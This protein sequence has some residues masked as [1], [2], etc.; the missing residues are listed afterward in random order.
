MKYLVLSL[1]LLTTVCIHAQDRIKTITG[2][3]IHAE[4]LDVDSYFLYYKTEAEAS[5]RT[6]L[7]TITALYIADSLK[8]QTLSVK[9]IAFKSLLVS[10]EQM[11]STAPNH[12]SSY[13]SESADHLQRGSNLFLTGIAVGGL[14]GLIGG[15]VSVSNPDRAAAVLGI[16]SLVVVVIEIIGYVQ[17]LKAGKKLEEAADA[18]KRTQLPHR[19]PSLK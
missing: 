4:V 10:L 18:A 2:N 5:N 13:L 11:E 8:I 3:I 16:T 9:S 17:F 19:S 1:L 7:N 6:S 15:V 12:L 14:G